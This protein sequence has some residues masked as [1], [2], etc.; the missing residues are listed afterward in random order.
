MPVHSA[1]C[2]QM[3]SHAKNTKPFSQQLTE[4]LPENP[5]MKTEARIV[6]NQRRMKEYH[7]HLYKFT[8]AHTDA[9]NTAMTIKKQKPD[10]TV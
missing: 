9:H 1:R 2:T 4:T 7:I 10:E 5:K 6:T 8:W 3:L